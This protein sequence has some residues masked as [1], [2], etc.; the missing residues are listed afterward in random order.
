MKSYK[1]KKLNEY[2]YTLE[3]ITTVLKIYR[4][5]F[6]LRAYPCAKLINTFRKSRFF[7]T[8]PPTERIARS[9]NHKEDVK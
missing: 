3:N 9:L 2:H 4:M 7:I 8:S 1:K 5:K 6:I